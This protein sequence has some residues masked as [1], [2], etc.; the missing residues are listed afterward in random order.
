MATP[1]TFKIVSLSTP[2]AFQ[3]KEKVN[4][5]YNSLICSR[6][7]T[8]PLVNAQ[9]NN[10][11]LDLT[12]VCTVKLP[13]GLPPGSMPA[14]I[15]YVITSVTGLVPGQIVTFFNENADFDYQIVGGVLAAGIIYTGGVGGAATKTIETN[16]LTGTSLL[17]TPAV[18]WYNGT[19]SGMY[20][21]GGT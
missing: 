3:S 15:Q 7:F 16:A 1:S 21:N 6:V 5:I 13:A 10:Y 9:V 14:T 11:V 8:L 17:T 20:F 18:G 12:G 2:S 19:A 4:K